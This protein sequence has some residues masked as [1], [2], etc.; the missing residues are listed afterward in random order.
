MREISEGCP[1][2]FP[3]GRAH[4]KL[5]VTNRAA[6]MVTVQVLSDAASHPPQPVK[7]EPTAGV[8]VKVTVVPPT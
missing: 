2:A 5:A 7:M 6:V 8:A 1:A 3:E 4:A